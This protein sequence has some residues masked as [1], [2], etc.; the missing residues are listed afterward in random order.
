MNTPITTSSEPIHFNN[1]PGSRKIWTVLCPRFSG[2]HDACEIL[3][4]CPVQVRHQAPGKLKGLFIQHEPVAVSPSA[5][6]TRSVLLKPAGL[7]FPSLRF[8]S[9]SSSSSPVGNPIT[10][11][12]YAIMVSL[13]E[14]GTVISR[15]AGTHCSNFSL[16]CSRRTRTPSGKFAAAGGVDVFSAFTGVK[17]IHCPA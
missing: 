9:K 13:G 12:P 2:F 5:V 15:P 14:V 10:F 1:Q 11:Q 3:Y 7:S 17:S 6:T 8:T 16:L 4:V